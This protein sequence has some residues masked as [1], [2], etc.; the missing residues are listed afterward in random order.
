MM[1]A[2]TSGWFAEATAGPAFA[3]YGAVDDAGVAEHLATGATAI[4]LGG[5][6]GFELARVRLDVGLRIQHFRIGVRGSY[7]AEKRDDA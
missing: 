2:D 5:G 3:T 4:A 6:Y 1:D 7:N